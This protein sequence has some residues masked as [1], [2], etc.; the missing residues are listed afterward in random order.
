MKLSNQD[1]DLKTAKAI[2]EILR[3]SKEAVD[4]Y[5]KERIEFLSSVA[6]KDKNGKPKEKKGDFVIPDDKMEE[7]NNTL[8]K[9]MNEEV[10]LPKL[11][12][13]KLGSLKLTA[14]DF[15]VIEL[16]LS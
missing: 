11:D 14:Q 2:L 16:L 12:A 3:A 13:D 6:E 15:S 9:M 10:D 4:K 8:S 7:V 1:V 5:N